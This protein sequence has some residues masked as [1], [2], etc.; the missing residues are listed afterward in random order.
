MPCEMTIKNGKKTW[1]CGEHLNDPEPPALCYKCGEPATRLC[2]Y[3]A[4]GLVRER[5][6][7]GRSVFKNGK[8]VKRPHTS[9]NTCDRP[10][11]D[12]CSNRTGD[13]DFCDEHNNEVCGEATRRSESLFQGMLA[14]LP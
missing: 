13:T 9:M 1:F 12:A 8:P 6:E 4:Y 10:M 14:K 2:D 5:D 3:R 11:C 7:R